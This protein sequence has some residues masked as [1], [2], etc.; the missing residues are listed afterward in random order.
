[1]D[2]KGTAVE[3]MPKFI[4]SKFGQD[5]LNSWIETLSEECKKIFR[6]PY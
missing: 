2:V 4:S 5:G 6:G 1:M 3:A